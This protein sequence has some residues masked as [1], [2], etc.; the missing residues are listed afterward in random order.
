M[1]E[2]RDYYEVLGVQKGASDDEIK[3]A[4]RK[5]AKE[6]HPDRNKDNPKAAENKMKEVNEAYDIL[7]DPQKKA[8]YDQYGHDAFRNGTGASAGAGGGFDGFEGFGGFEDIFGSFFGGGARQR[9]NGP[10]RGA[11]LRYDMELEFTEAA[12]GVNKEI[13]KREHLIWL[14]NL[15]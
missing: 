2:K 6:Y 15:S 7:K 1:S 8:A 13:I 12:F 4:Y 3:K 14:D 11:D 9:R 10:E 5:K